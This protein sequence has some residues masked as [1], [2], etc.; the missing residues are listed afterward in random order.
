MNIN[1][2][3]HSPLNIYHGEKNNY[4]SVTD[5]TFFRPQSAVVKDLVGNSSKLN[6]K[7]DYPDGEYKDKPDLSLLHGFP[8]RTE[9]NTIVSSLQNDI[10]KRVKND[11]EENE[12]KEFRKLDKDFKEGVLKSLSEKNDNSVDSSSVSSD[13]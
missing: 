13:S 2:F 6:H 11:L 5:K 4:D 9:V 10:E 3:H 8:D 12:F 1:F 7:Y